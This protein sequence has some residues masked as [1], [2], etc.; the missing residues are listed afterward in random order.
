MHISNGGTVDFENINVLSCGG[1]G[2][3]EVEKNG[4]IEKES[5]DSKKI[6]GN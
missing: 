6:I 2:V 4:V 5:S 1:V 3:N